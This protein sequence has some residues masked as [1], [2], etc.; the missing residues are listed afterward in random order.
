[1]VQDALRPHGPMIRADVALVTTVCCGS[2]TAQ[3]AATQAPLVLISRTIDVCPTMQHGDAAEAAGDLGGFDNFQDFLEGHDIGGGK[4]GT[5]DDEDAVDLY[6]RWDSGDGVGDEDNDDD[7]DAMGMMDG[8]AITYADFF[9]HSAPYQ[10]SSGA[11]DGSKRRHA[12]R[13]EQVNEALAQQ[14]AEQPH[15]GGDC[16]AIIGPLSVSFA[17]FVCQCWPWL[18]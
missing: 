16:G 1:M 6:G 2:A 9:G 13:R 10:R 17:D 3:S 14:A 18:S 7:D 5:E 12:Q 11:L 4:D 8:S 15:P